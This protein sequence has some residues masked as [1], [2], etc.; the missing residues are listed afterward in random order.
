MR[1]LRGEGPGCIDDRWK[2]VLGF[3]GG[4]GGS[5][6]AVGE[7]LEEHVE[8]GGREGRVSERRGEEGA[9]DGD[10]ARRGGVEG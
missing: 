9:A 3:W 4:E 1:S 7:H 2:S 8:G 6:D 5:G 10:L